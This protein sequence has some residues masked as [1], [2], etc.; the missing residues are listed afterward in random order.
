MVLECLCEHAYHNIDRHSVKVWLKNKG[1]ARISHVGD[2]FGYIRKQLVLCF[3][4]QTQAKW[5]SLNG[6]SSCVIA[7][8]ENHQMQWQ[9]GQFCDLREQQ[10]KG[11]TQ[12]IVGQTHPGRCLLFT[13]TQ[14]STSPHTIPPCF[15]GTHCIDKFT[16]QAC[17]WHSFTELQNKHTWRIKEQDCIITSKS[18]IVQV[19]VNT[20]CRGQHHSTMKTVPTNDYGGKRLT[21]IQARKCTYY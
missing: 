18:L 1:W 12:R 16:C 20:Y 2:I 17:G 10:L 9:A 21:G 8:S 3:A 13:E 19:A 5:F 6:R 15:F 7:M 4:S 14:C 11:F